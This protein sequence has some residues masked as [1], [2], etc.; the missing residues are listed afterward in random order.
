MSETTQNPMKP[1]FQMQRTMLESSQQATHDVVEAQKEAV[2]QMT[3]SV[4]QY[5]SFSEQNADLSKK[6]LHAYFDAVESMMPEGTMD[7]SEFE[8]LLDEQY[9]ALT[10]NQAQ[11]MTAAVEAMEENA[12]AFDQY[13]DSYTEVVDSSFDSFLEAHERIEGNFEDATEQLEDAA[14]ELSA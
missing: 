13:A 4:E 14:E 8:Q 3:E 1:V 6:A 11:M 7:F 9:D 5:Q 10:E 12:D 2:A